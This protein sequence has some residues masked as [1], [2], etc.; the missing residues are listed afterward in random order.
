M[1][2][3]GGTE[4]KHEKYN[5]FPAREPVILKNYGGLDSS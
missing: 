4:E 1:F 2:S 3:R 5:G